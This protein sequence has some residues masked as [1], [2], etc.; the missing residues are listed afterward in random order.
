MSDHTFRNP[1]LYQVL[2]FRDF[3]REVM[4]NGR[5]GFVAEDLDL[6]LR[7]YGPKYHLDSVGLFA[8]VEI[9]VGNAPI[10]I[11]RSKNMTFGL[12]DRII[13]MGDKDLQKRYRGWYVIVT[14]SLEW[15]CCDY[16]WVNGIKL[17]P[18]TFIDWLSLD[19]EMNAYQF[20]Q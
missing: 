17:T 2:P 14:N 9:K 1:E 13:R 5:E 20:P 16:F 7:W 10:S 8:L 18:S 4:P 11:G 6:I 15:E 3:L 12:I 19:Y